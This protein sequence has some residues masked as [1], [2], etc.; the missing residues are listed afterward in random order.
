MYLMRN[1]H[2]SPGLA[3]TLIAILCV[4][5]LSGALLCGCDNPD[6]MKKDN[7]KNT[8]E[9]VMDD[10]VK[11]VEADDAKSTELAD[12]NDLAELIKLNG[13]RIANIDTVYEDIVVL[14]P[15]EEYWAIHALTL[16]YLVAVR[17][18]LEA[19]NDYYEALVAGDPSEDLGTIAQRAATK[20]QA[21]GMELAVEIRKSDLE[22]ES[23][24]EKEQDQ[25]QPETSQPIESESTDGGQ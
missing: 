22:L 16:Y 10:F 1:I 23:M 25:P 13:E 19:Q 18:Q 9:K 12:N 11:R 5:A 14:M 2:E 21:V 8:Y 6:Q 4:C 7:Y 3:V 17:E 15:P 24:P 20:A